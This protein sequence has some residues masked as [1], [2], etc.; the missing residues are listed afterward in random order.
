MSPNETHENVPSTCPQF[1]NKN[2]SIKYLFQEV[3]QSFIDMLQFIKL[4]KPT[5]THDAII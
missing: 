1:T 5:G 4:A 2:K 3:R